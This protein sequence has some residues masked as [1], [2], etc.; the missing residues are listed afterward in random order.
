M[1][2]KLKTLDELYEILK[3]DRDSRWMIIMEATIVL[4]FIVDVVLIFKTPG[5]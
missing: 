5:R 2:S 3:A 1:E 4:L